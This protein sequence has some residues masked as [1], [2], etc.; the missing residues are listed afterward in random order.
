[1]SKEQNKS[2]PKEKKSVAKLML[3]VFAL[4]VVFNIA[5]SAFDESK[6][7]R[8]K[9]D[10]EVEKTN[11]KCIDEAEV[12]D[13]SDIFAMM[14]QNEAALARSWKNSCVKV[15][16]KVKGISEGVRGITVRVDDGQKFN[17]VD[18]IMCDPVDEKK[19]LTLK[20]GQDIIVKGIGGAEVM[21]SLAL[22]KC[23]W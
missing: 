7:D 8:V 14:K 11:Q 20:K 6:Q 13:A 19:A 21:G 4:A 16:G 10:K 1:M 3:G 2:D 18:N 23:D 9:R 15:R 17:I 5:A 22:K 12:V